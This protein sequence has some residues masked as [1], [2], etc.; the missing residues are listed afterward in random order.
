MHQRIFKEI[1]QNSSKPIFQKQLLFH[2]GFTCHCS[3]FQIFQAF[4]YKQNSVDGHTHVHTGRDESSSRNTLYVRKD[5]AGLTVLCFGKIAHK[6]KG[7]KYSLEFRGCTLNNLF[8]SRQYFI[9][10]QGSVTNNHPSSVDAYI[11]FYLSCGCSV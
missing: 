4:T 11:S 3:Q 8:S 2:Q 6:S 5:N 7:R 9:N 1:I 10:N